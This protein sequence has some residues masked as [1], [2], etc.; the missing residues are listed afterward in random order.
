M[1]CKEI[2]VL[3]K[4]IESTDNGLEIE[5]PN[6]DGCFFVKK[7]SAF[8]GYGTEITLFEEEDK[9][10]NRKIDFEK[11]KT[12]I[13][14][15]ICNLQLDIQ[16][17]IKDKNYKFDAFTFRK[18]HKDTP[19][20]FIP[21]EE[22]GIKSLDYNSILNRSFENQYPFGLFVIFTKKGTKKGCIEFNEGI[23]LS[24]TTTDKLIRAGR[25][26]C[27]VYNFPSSYIQL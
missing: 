20:L 21:F 16:L 11:I 2:K 8:E 14:E 19:M 5:I 1:V 3:T 25:L 18:N 12:Y 22:G 15:T 7:G 6:Y 26:C 4:S 13:E 27:L 24:E 9:S 17:K 23:K 10:S